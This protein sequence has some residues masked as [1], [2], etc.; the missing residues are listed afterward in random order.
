MLRETPT[1]LH[2]IDNQGR[3]Q[4]V[5]DLW[6]EKL[7]YTWDEVIG[8]RSVDF[9]SEESRR[10]AREVVLPMFFKTGMCEVEYDMVRKDGTLMP[11]RLRGVAV[12]NESGAFLRSIAVI[13][14]LSEKRALERKMFDAQKLEGLA[15]MAGN[16]AHD[17]NNLL[18]TVV[19][20]AQLVRR[21]AGSD[22]AVESS[23]DGILTATARAAD[24]CRQL[25]AYSGRGRFQIET[26][27]LGALVTEMVKVLGVNVKR[28]AVI[29]LV[30][31][32][33]DTRVEVDATQIRQIVMNLVI[34]A[35]EAMDDRVGQIRIA[36]LLCDLDEAM[37]A[38]SS[39]P[40]IRPGRYVCL[41][42]ADTGRGMPPDDVARIFDP[43][44][45][46]KATG[47]G[48]GLA[49]VQGIVRGHHGSLQ[50][51]SE[52]G[53]GTRFRV[54]LPRAAMAATT[55]SVE[56]ST[57]RAHGTVLVV[58]DDDDL[59]LVL[60]RQLVEFGY[61]AM[62]AASSQEAAELARGT[63]IDVF[64][65]DVTMPGDSGPDL[66]RR[67]LDERPSARI[68]MMSGYDGVSIALPGVTFLAKPFDHGQLVRA[69]EG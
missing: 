32:A 52:V 59:R 29:E 35:A 27:D 16:L 22:P 3:I 36:T 45:T 67:L 23:V 65:I 15:L 20:N 5:S 17:F 28:R 51:R 12:R 50:V 42:I 19:G 1:M 60:G 46:T 47:R 30:L 6:L 53:G 10:Y 68:V 48:L 41:E 11:V 43:F 55:R 33:D 13:E 44:F 61:R 57:P 39:Q 58:D 7:Q 69:L 34:N 31:A 63:A 37:I 38:A 25:L 62:L 14:D 24:L 64:L 56:P 8:R 4:E 21:H 54:F 26:I 18:A 49:A 9:L 66:A 2:S 40:E